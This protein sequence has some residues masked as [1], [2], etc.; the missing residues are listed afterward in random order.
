[1]DA[2]VISDGFM[3]T[4][5]TDWF[6]SAGK[7]VNFR[8]QLHSLIV[9][10]VLTSVSEYS[11]VSLLFCSSQA[12]CEKISSTNLKKKHNLLNRMDLNDFDQKSEIKNN[13]SL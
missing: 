5:I 12:L 13:I 8:A 3:Q 11:R 6:W 7:N 1:M 10:R 2:R 9:W 4:Y